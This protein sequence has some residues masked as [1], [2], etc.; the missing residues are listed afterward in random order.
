MFLK[1]LIILILK[2]TDIFVNSLQENYKN[3]IPVFLNLS[4]STNWSPIGEMYLSS[5]PMTKGRTN[6]ILNMHD[7][8]FTT[9]LTVITDLLIA[10]IFVYTTKMK[11]KIF[12]K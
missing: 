6:K 1:M 4:K 3:I 2:I 8:L 12:L 9:K 5:K 11:Q 7:N 10:R